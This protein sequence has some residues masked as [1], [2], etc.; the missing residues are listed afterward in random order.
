MPSCSTMDF[1]S[2]ADALRRNH[3]LEIIS[4]RSSGF[5]KSPKSRMDTRTGGGTPSRLNC[6]WQGCRL[7]M[8]RFCWDTNRS[9]SPRDITL[10][11]CS[12]AKSSLR[13]RSWLQSNDTNLI[14]LQNNIDKKHAQLTT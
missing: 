10:R 4:E 6:Y 1:T 2:G 5:M 12:H 7:P 9:K 3:A 13:R 11:G 14:R 8:S